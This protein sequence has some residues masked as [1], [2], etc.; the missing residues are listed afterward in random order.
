MASSG[1]A[2]GL[3]ALFMVLGFMMVATF[4][5][6]VAIYGLPHRDELLSPWSVATFVDFCINLM[7]LVAWVSYKESN[8]FSALL[9]IILLVVL[10]RNA[11]ECRAKYSPII[12]ARIAF[13]ALG[14]LM[15]GTLL[16]TLFTYGHPFRKELLTP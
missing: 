10:G 8:W 13:S 5:Y 1:L 15:L 16:Y 14:C 3:K 12:I 4:I 9:W 6:T 7:A 2:A 11:V